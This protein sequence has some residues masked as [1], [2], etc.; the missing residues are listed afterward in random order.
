MKLRIRYS[1]LGK[2]RFTSH[3]D[4]AN[5]FERAVRKA[6][7]LLAYSAGFTPRPRMSFGL[8]LPTGGESLAE[9]LDMELAAGYTPDPVELGAWLAAE[10]PVGYEVAA[11]A[12]LAQGSPSLQEDVV[13]CT[14]EIALVGVDPGAA[15]AAVAAA[16]HGARRRRKDQRSTDGVRAIEDLSVTTVPDDSR[17][18]CACAGHQRTGPAPDGARRR[19]PPPRPGRCGRRVLRH[20][21]SPPVLGW[22]PRR[23]RSPAHLWVREKDA[24][25]DR[26]PIDGSGRRLRRAEPQD[27]PDARRTTAAMPKMVRRVSGSRVCARRTASAD[28]VRVAAATAASRAPRASRV[29][30]VRI[31]M[32]MSMSMT[33]STMTS[34]RPATTS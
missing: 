25:D 19:C 32:S 28:V 21:F 6:Q 26:Q 3:R 22:S 13:A 9:Y 8:A 24:T 11:V 14:W 7:V 33:M 17:H 34:T 5:H 18:T 29:P 30:P 31:P 27:V 2:I 4:T 23:A 15:Q 1:K 12:E 20:R 16:S 10:L